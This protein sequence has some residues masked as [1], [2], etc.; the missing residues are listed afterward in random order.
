MTAENYKSGVNDHDVH[1]C[2]PKNIGPMQVQQGAQG[3]QEDGGADIVCTHFTNC[4][5]KDSMAHVWC[6][7]SA[8]NLFPVC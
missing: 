7:F 3:G 6:F 4:T 1:V 2:R 8:I 5:A